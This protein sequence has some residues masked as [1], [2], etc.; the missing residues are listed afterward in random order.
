VAW[1]GRTGSERRDGGSARISGDLPRNSL[2]K[3]D[4]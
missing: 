1:S 3:A 4:N 2:I